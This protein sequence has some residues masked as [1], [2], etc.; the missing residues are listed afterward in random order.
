ML[1]ASRSNG[2]SVGLVFGLLAGLFLGLNAGLIV[3]L[4]YGLVY[5]LLVGL[6]AG[7]ISGLDAWLYHYWLRWRLAARDVLPPEL[8]AFL[9]WCAEDERGWLRISDAYE[10][11]HRELLE[12]L[13]PD[14]TPLD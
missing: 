11:R 13:A 5:V 4:V 10:F 14:M 6:V 2:L 7:L 3:G 9:K 8:P 1:V 12:H